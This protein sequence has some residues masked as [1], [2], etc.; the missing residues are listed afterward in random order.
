MHHFSSKLTITVLVNIKTFI[1][2]FME[3]LP[4]CK[5]RISCRKRKLPGEISWRKAGEKG[6]VKVKSIDYMVK[7]KISWRNAGEIPLGFRHEI[8]QVIM[9]K[10]EKCVFFYLYSTVSVRKN[11]QSSRPIQEFLLRNYTNPKI[12]GRKS[13]L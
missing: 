6:A 3:K 5:I 12:K 2:C 13:S 11:I 4:E 9:E 10:N 7:H 8:L 1:S